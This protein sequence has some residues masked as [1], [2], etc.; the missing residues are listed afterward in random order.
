MP[1]TLGHDADHRERVFVQLDGGA[2]GRGIPS[3]HPLPRAV[4][5]RDDVPDVDAGVLGLEA[6][7]QGRPGAQHLEEVVRDQRHRDPL[8]AFAAGE[9]GVDQVGG[10]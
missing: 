3:V 10:A 5:E 4:A 2:E 7:A 6:A 9:V 8:G 1:E